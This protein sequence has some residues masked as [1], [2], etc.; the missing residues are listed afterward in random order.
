ML[1]TQISYQDNNKKPKRH[2]VHA[3]CMQCKKAHAACSHTRPCDR[4]IRT[5]QPDA[6]ADGPRVKRIKE[7]SSNVHSPPDMPLPDSVFADEVVNLTDSTDLSYLLLDTPASL[8]LSNDFIPVFGD[9]HQTPVPTPT[10]PLNSSYPSTP[11]LLNNPPMFTT[12]PQHAQ[13]APASTSIPSFIQPTPN[14][15]MMSTLTTLGNG[16]DVTHQL[17]HYVK[18]ME[19][20]IQHLKKE[21]DDLRQEVATVKAA[22]VPTPHA[23]SIPAPLASVKMVGS[24]SGFGHAVWSIPDLYLVQYNEDFATLLGCQILP[25]QPY[26]F[27]NLFKMEDDSENHNN[28]PTAL[29]ESM[30]RLKVG[31]GTNEEILH[32]CTAVHSEVGSVK[33]KLRRYN[34][35]TFTCAITAQI[36]PERNIIVTFMYE[37]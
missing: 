21:V 28:C 26:H 10:N 5:N 1:A 22:K 11:E 24:G 36:L 12:V 30:E 29:R 17:L 25:F 3:A 32:A 16:H 6:C 35:T 37:V 14:D 9:N 23:N 18:R 33:K 8:E 7:K 20:T 19:T 2:Q 31:G 4:C 13:P 34:G 15:T 27:T